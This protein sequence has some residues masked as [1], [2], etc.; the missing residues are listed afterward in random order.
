MDFSRIELR[1]ILA[2]IN[3]VGVDP[4]VLA[5]LEYGATNLAAPN[6]TRLVSA[7]HN[8]I[9][10]TDDRGSAYD[11]DVFHPMFLT[12]KMILNDWTQ[13]DVDR[14]NEQTKIQWEA[15]RRIR[16]S[17]K[18]IVGEKNAANPNAAFAEPDIPKA[19]PVEL[20]KVG[21]K[22]RWGDECVSYQGD[23]PAFRC[24]NGHGYTY[25][26]VV[27]GCPLCFLAGSRKSEEPVDDDGAI[28]GVDSA[29]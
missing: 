7:Q 17:Y 10:Q 21:Q 16:K 23:Q 11:E 24:S 27:P 12:E 2:N 28:E 6:P 3:R 29:W 22:N 13:E 19:P 14:S 1:D 26:G 20:S 8:P 18:P 15:Q 4:D 5:K 25:N 9:I